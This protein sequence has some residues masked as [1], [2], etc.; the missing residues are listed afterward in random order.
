MDEIIEEIVEMVKDN[1]KVYMNNDKYF[2][3]LKTYYKENY[4]NKTEIISYE[5]LVYLVTDVLVDII[6]SEYLYDFRELE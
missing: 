6:N 2:V 3:G 4:Y 1:I 5:R